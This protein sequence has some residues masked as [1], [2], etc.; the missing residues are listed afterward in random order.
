VQSLVARQALARGRR[1]VGRKVRLTSAAVQA[2]L[3]VDSGSG[4]TCLGDPVAA[5]VRL[6]RASH[7]LGNA[8][9]AG[10]VILSGALGLMVPVSPGDQRLDVSRAE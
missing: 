5:L 2:R 6:A 8:L 10:E 4:A 9:R 7:Q 3:G 1:A